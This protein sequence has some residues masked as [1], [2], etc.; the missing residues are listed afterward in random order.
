M[1]IRTPSGNT[2]IL[3]ENVPME[4]LVELNIEWED[5][6]EESSTLHDDSPH[7]VL[8]DKIKFIE[9]SEQSAP[10]E[11]H[12]WIVEEEISPSEKGKKISSSK[13]ISSLPK[14]RTKSSITAQVEKM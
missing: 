12:P 6:H 13:F 2:E 7:P 3:P 11:F 8:S 4:E 14:W 5:M 10:I 9:I 1:S